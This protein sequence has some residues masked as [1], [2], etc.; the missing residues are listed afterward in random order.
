M[1]SIRIKANVCIYLEREREREINGFSITVSCVGKE[2]MRL[3]LYF[4]GFS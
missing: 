1:L 2:K 3:L 4:L